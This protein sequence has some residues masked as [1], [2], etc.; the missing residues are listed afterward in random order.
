MLTEQAGCFVLLSNVPSS[1]EGALDAKALMLRYKGQYGVESDFSFLKDPLVVNDLFLKKPSR[2]DALG[3]ILVVA[4]LIWRLMERQMRMHLAQ[5]GKMLP[6]W[7]NRPTDRPTIS[8][9]HAPDVGNRYCSIHWAIV[10]CSFST[11]WA[12]SMS[13]YSWTMGSSA[14]CNAGGSLVVEQQGTSSS[15]EGVPPTFRGRSFGGVPCLHDDS[16]NERIQG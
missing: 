8:R 6:G 7:D 2:V 10:R 15:E 12:S 16:Q 1:G 5:E 3:M 13:V 9:L 14:Y 11:P 4:L